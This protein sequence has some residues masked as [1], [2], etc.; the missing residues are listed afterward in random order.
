MKMRFY[1]LHQLPSKLPI[2]Q[3][4]QERRPNHRSARVAMH[5]RGADLHHLQ[6]LARY[7][8]RAAVRDCP[9][10]LHVYRSAHWHRC[11]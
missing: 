4:R 3:W 1:D 10:S 7:P 9:E 2:W 5:R 11:C 8:G 6:R